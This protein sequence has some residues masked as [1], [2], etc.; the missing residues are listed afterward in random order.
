MSFIVPQYKC[1]ACGTIAEAKWTGQP[2]WDI[3]DGWHEQLI[4]GKYFEYCG[5]C[6]RPCGCGQCGGLPSHECLANKMT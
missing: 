5:D 2:H 1:D 3:P 4:D 6:I